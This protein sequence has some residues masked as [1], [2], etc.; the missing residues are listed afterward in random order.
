MPP[1]KR[2]L[3]DETHLVRRA[4][5]QLRDSKEHVERRDIRY[6]PG[7]TPPALSDWDSQ[8]ESTSPHTP[9]PLFHSCDINVCKVCDKH[10]NK[11]LLL[12][13]H[14]C[15]TRQHTYCV[16][17]DPVD[18]G[19]WKCELCANLVTLFP[20]QTPSD[21]FGRPFFD[22]VRA[23]MNTLMSPLERQGG[24]TLGQQG[25]E[26]LWMKQEI[27]RLPPYKDFPSL[28]EMRNLDLPEKEQDELRDRVARQQR[29]KLNFFLTQSELR[30]H[31]MAKDGNTGGVESTAEGPSP[32]V[33]SQER[34]DDQKEDHIASKAGGIDNY[35][36]SPSSLILK[37]PFSADDT[38]KLYITSTISQDCTNED[39]GCG[40]LLIALKDRPKNL[41]FKS[42]VFEPGSG[43]RLRLR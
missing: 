5:D 7:D 36:I 2:K 23:D 1:R 41:A 14:R 35:G 43:K 24:S 42:S 40:L 15:Y 8:R 37:T 30:S 26:M 39:A 22:A 6:P 3:G 17:I 31:F 18:G 20:P 34:Q 12:R 16:G 38:T 29:R 33:L 21:L 9:P 19:K 32:V 25:Q 13:C 27:A 10:D 4:L 11:D 28:R